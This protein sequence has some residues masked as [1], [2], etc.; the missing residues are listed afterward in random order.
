MESLSF[1]AFIENIFESTY[2]SFCIQEYFF[3]PE[4]L[5]KNT[6]NIDENF[7]LYQPNIEELTDTQRKQGFKV[8]TEMSIYSYLKELYEYAV[9]GILGK[10][11]WVD[12]IEE[13][14]FYFQHVESD[15]SQISEEA[16]LILDMAHLRFGMDGEKDLISFNYSNNPNQVI[17]KMAG[18]DERTVRNAASEGMFT[19]DGVSYHT[20]AI[21]IW[22]NNKKGFKRTKIDENHTGLQLDD[23]Q[24][25]QQ[26]G[27]LISIQK[28]NLGKLLDEKKFKAS[29]YNFDKHTLLNLES[30]IFDLPLNTVSALANAFHFDEKALLHCIMRVFFAHELSLIKE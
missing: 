29:H 9:E 24:T 5:V 13:V 1:K 21:K 27:Q 8:F 3:G 25:A 6:F 26:F 23:I 14:N 11:H 10:N 30:G 12:L 20:E 16:K 18:L 22:L 28:A 7:S 19:H 15:F 17:A 4:N 2:C